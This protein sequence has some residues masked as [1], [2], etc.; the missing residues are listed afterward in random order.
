[1]PVPD[2]GIAKV[3]LEALEVIVTLPVAVPADVG[4]NETVK[5]A[6]C[7][8]VKVSGAVIPLRLNPVPVIPT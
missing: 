8:A 1:M 3:G 6:L 2:S 4:L 7:P 5:L